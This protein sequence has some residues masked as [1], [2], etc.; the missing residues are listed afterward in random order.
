MSERFLVCPWCKTP[1]DKKYTVLA[2]DYCYCPTCGR[3]LSIESANI[4]VGSWCY[5]RIEELSLKLYC[6]EDFIMR[7]KR[8]LMVEDDGN[9]KWEGERENAL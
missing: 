6:V 9:V 5:K 2:G 8:H 7:L 3:Y 1:I 4:D